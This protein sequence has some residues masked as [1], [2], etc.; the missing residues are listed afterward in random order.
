MVLRADAAVFGN[1]PLRVD[2]KNLQASAGTG[3]SYVGK[4]PLPLG[5]ESIAIFTTDMAINLRYRA[6][7]VGIIC[8]N[9]FDRRYRIGEYNYASDFKSRDYP[10]L[11]A[12]RHFSAGEP[13]AIYGT[14][15]LTLDG[16]GT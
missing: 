5:E 4:R 15:T 1:L 2:G 7:Q 9:L 10:T 13:R 3:V 8:T 16:D 6:V 11:V 12:A 14:L